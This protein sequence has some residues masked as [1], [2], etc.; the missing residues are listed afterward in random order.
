MPGAETNENEVFRFAIPVVSRSLLISPLLIQHHLPAS[1][2]PIRKMQKAFPP[3]DNR[4][5]K[6]QAAVE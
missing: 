4:L 6:R 5:I 2:L 1:S 3:I